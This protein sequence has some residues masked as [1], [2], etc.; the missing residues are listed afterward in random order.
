MRGQKG[1]DGDAHDVTASWYTAVGVA[2]GWSRSERT[3]RDLSHVVN[4]STSTDTVSGS[5][6]SMMVYRAQHSTAQ[7]S[8]QHGTAIQHSN[9]TA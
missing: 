1:N 6:A 2:R 3:P 9:S 4:S 8:T 5:V 7:H